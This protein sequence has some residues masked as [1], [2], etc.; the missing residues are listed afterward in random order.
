MKQML[1]V[2]FSL[3]VGTLHAQKTGSPHRLAVDTGKIN[4]VP[5]QKIEKGWAPHYVSIQDSL[6]RRLKQAWGK[7]DEPWLPYK[8]KFQ[9][10]TF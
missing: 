2:L 4:T 5:Y 1:L 8:S 10:N 3:V 6:K 9:Q 7:M